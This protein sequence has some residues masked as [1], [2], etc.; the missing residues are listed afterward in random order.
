MGDLAE[1]TDLRD[2]AIELD[3]DDPVNDIYEDMDRPYSETRVDLGGP[4]RWRSKPKRM[5]LFGTKRQNSSNAQIHDMSSCLF[6]KYYVLHSLQYPLP[7]NKPLPQP[8][9]SNSPNASFGAVY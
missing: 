5:G 3:V 1:R 8:E 2:R 7:R 4:G 9:R 6:L